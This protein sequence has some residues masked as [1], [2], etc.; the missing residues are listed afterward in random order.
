[1]KWMMMAALIAAPV[2]AQN[3]P[4][5]RLVTLKYADPYAARELLKHFGVSIQADRQMKMLALT[6]PKSAVETAESALKQ[7]DM[8]GAA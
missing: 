2:W 1:M 5:H 6:G 3:D 4:V 8:P 7:L